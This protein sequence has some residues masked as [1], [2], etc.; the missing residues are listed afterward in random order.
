MS[1]VEY[2]DFGS[3]EASSLT[4]QKVSNMFNILPIFADLSD[5]AS[6]QTYFFLI[7]FL[8]SKSEKDRV[9]IGNVEISLTRGFAV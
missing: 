3:Q 9:N 7:L 6:R 8:T 4:F 2:P 1:T 5:S